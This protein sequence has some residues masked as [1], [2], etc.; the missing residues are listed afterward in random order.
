MPWSAVYR[1]TDGRLESLTTTVP[2]GL[3]APLAAKQLAAG[4]DPSLLWD[5]TV[6]DWKPRP[7]EVL[8]DRLQDLADDP[9]LS[10]V[11]S[12]LTVAQRQT[13]RDRL[14]ALLGPR[15]WRRPAEPVDLED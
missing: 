14:A 9:V 15:R 6:A 13:L 3:S 11:W 7:A 5:E 4:P 12:R 10:T 2:T 8:A 1:T